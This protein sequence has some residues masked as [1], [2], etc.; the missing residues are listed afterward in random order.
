MTRKRFIGAGSLFGAAAAMKLYGAVGES[1]PFRAEDYSALRKQLRA[2]YPKDG[3]GNKMTPQDPRAV[4][5]YRRIEADLKAW[6]PPIPVMTRSTY[7][8]N[9]IF[10]C[11]SISCRRIWG[12]TPRRVIISFV[13][14]GIL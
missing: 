6:A 10:R 5:S 9:A 12:E 14:P 4:A 13:N 7:A 8:V 3:Q 1:R 11:G 2:F